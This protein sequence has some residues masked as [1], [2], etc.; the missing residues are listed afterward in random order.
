[1]VRSLWIRTLATTLVWTGVTWAQQSTHAPDD[2][3]AE[4]I[5]TIQ[6]KGKS[7]QKCKVINT[8]RTNDGHLAY[9]VRALDTGEMLTITEKI[10]STS[11]FGAKPASVATQIFHWGPGQVSPANAPAPPTSAA[12]T[13][14][15]QSA[16][17][18][19]SAASPYTFQRADSAKSIA[20]SPYSSPT[21][22]ATQPDS[23]SKNITLPEPEK[24]WRQSWAKAEEKPLRIE[25][26]P[27]TRDSI[28]DA[29]RLKIEDK[30]SA[31]QAAFDLSPAKKPAATQPKVALTPDDPLL[32]PDMYMPKVLDVTPLR[33]SVDSSTVQLPGGPSPARAPTL[34]DLAGARTEQKSPAALNKPMVAFDAGKM[35]APALPVITPPTLVPTLPSATDKPLISFDSGTKKDSPVAPAM[36]PISPLVLVP[37]LPSMDKPTAVADANKSPILAA[38]PA[39]PVISQPAPAPTPTPVEGPA[40]VVDAGMMPGALTP[41]KMPV[42]VQPKIVPAMPAFE[43]KPGLVIE[44]GK[45]GS[46]V[47]IPALPAIVQ[48]AFTPNLAPALNMPKVAVGHVKP[49]VPVIIPEL[50]EVAPPAVIPAMSIAE[51]KAEPT[52]S[53]ERHRPCDNSVDACDSASADCGHR[54]AGPKCHGS[55]SG[56][57][58]SVAANTGDS[59][60]TA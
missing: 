18:G 3:K 38:P 36:P 7:P 20:P 14:S 1:M 4:Q 2:K 42:I 45:L 27:S 54:C 50:P 17:T 21:K 32:H 52:D 28:A 10:T 16:Q 30:P 29:P 48:P 31:K 19:G 22:P 11:T 24:D 23:G 46:P 6:E 9:Q 43:E 25:D 13:D 12:A 59:G 47:S 60:R 40:I 5:L 57:S 37:T 49:A 15:K 41:P 35:P 44:T 55:A 26:K 56:F 53:A 34:A 51:K 8:W 33:K 58:G 39:M